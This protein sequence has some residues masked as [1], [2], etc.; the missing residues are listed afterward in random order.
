MVNWYLPNSKENSFS[1]QSS[2]GSSPANQLQMEN[3]DIFRQTKA[4]ICISHGL[5][6]GK[7][8]EDTFLQKKEVNQ[9]GQTGD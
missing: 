7:L 6:P 9:K 4:K 3:K 1:T 5:L 8:L 2:T